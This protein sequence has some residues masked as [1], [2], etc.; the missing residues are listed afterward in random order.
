MRLS[1]SF[2]IAT[3]PYAVGQVTPQMP[4]GMVH[5]AVSVDLH[6]ALS[7]TASQLALNLGAHI[8]P[9][10]SLPPL[11]IHPSMLSQPA[12]TP[13]TRYLRIV[14]ASFPVPID[15][16]APAHFAFLSIEDVLTA[17]MNGL[18][19]AL[20]REAIHARGLDERAVHAAYQQ[21]VA[22]F[23]GTEGYQRIQAAG[24]I[25]LDALYGRT[26]F[27]GFVVVVENEPYGSPPTLVLTTT[28]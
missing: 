20:P 19:H 10:Y 26:R 4:M 21:R 24:Y 9:S 6:P 22:R 7:I 8:P 23:Y 5:N 11:N 2:A 1:L 27:A 12:T 25:V 14:H 15:V 13:Q 17:L 18:Y 28:T 16:V 3:H